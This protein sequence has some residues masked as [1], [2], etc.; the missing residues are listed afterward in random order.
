MKKTVILGKESFSFVSISQP[1][2][3]NIVIE[4]GGVNSLSINELAQYATSFF[5]QINNFQYR[6]FQNLKNNST[7]LRQKSYIQNKNNILTISNNE[8]DTLCVSF[9]EF[10]NTFLSSNNIGQN[11]VAYIAANG[12]DVSTFVKEEKCSIKSIV[13]NKVIGSFKVIKDSIVN[14][15]KLFNINLKIKKLMEARV[16]FNFS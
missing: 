9:L 14:K 15:Y 5:N 10:N 16:R 6:L 12:I 2:I 1:T 4:T 7:D 8:I 3:D 13:L 11:R